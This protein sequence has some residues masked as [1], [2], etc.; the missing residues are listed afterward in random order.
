MSRKPLPLH[1]CISAVRVN[2]AAVARTVAGEVFSVPAPRRC[3]FCTTRG[4]AHK[5]SGQSVK[6]GVMVC[7]RGFCQMEVGVSKCSSCGQWVSRDGCEVHNYYVDDDD[8]R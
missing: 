8:S 1:D 4:E 7:S 3:A 2:G 6:K 5:L